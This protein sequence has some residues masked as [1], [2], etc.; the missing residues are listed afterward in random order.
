MP[1]REVAPAE[2]QDWLPLLDRELNRLPEKYRAAIVLCELEGRSRK[3]AAHLLGIPEGTLSSRLAMGRGMLARRLA[4]SGLALAG[5]ASVA[6]VSSALADSTV[7]AACGQPAASA[8]AVTLMQEVVKTMLV[9]KLRL[10]VGSV[11]VMA[12][13]GVVGLGYQVGN[14]PA[15]AQQGAPNEVEALR[16]EVEL[17]RLNLLVVLEKV[18]AQE[19]EL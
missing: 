10:V 8:A 1:H 19:A 6:S 2:P 7:R 18:R 11:L 14:N 9:K 3:E 4:R 17:L 15:V 13:L 12:A 16:R 5:A